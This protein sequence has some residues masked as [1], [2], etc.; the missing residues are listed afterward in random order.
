MH[1]PERGEVRQEGA[2]LVTARLAPYLLERSF[3]A[4]RAAAVQQ[5]GGALRR[6]LSS[7]ASTQAVGGARHQYGRLR[8]ISH[9]H[10]LP[11]RADSPPNAR[12]ILKHG[13]QD[14]ASVQEFRPA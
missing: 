3:E 5:H 8:R 2:Y 13:S 4:F 1:R 9:G 11:G 12:S 7:D 6:E 10:S 14:A